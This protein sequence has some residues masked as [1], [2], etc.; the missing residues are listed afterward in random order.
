LV[1]E[2]V[3]TGWYVGYVLGAVVIALVVAL[4]ARLLTLVR[5]I[6]LQ[7]RDIAAALDSVRATTTSLTGVAGLNDRLA[8]VADRAVRARTALTG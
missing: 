7:A 3:L 6:G 5:R 1:P 2:T 4:L 8:S